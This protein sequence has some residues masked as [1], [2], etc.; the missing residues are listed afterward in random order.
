MSNYKIKEVKNN[1]GI[2]KDNITGN[3]LYV[4]QRQ[5][6]DKQRL[7]MTYFLNPPKGKQFRHTGRC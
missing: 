4:P 5:W 2:F 7:V 6:T 3:V 1:V